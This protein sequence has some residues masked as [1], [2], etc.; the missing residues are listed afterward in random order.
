MLF[1]EMVQKLMEGT[2]C[3]RTLWQNSS[4][5]LSLM[6]TFDN[7]WMITNPEKLSL[8]G[9]STAHNYSPTIS[10]L[11]AD[12]WIEFKEKSKKKKLKRRKK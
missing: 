9:G 12:D 11:L 2:Y 3:T 5:Y 6:P 1:K 8:I 4:M 10:D 7:I